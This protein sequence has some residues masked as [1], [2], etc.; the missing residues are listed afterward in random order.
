MKD[1]NDNF[2][3]FTPEDVSLP[4]D[5]VYDEETEDEDEFDGDK[6]EEEYWRRQEEEKQEKRKEK[7]KAVMIAVAVLSIIVIVLLILFT[8]I[9]DTYRRNFKNNFDKL[10]YTEP[11]I[12]IGATEKNSNVQ[13]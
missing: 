8:S 7:F 12:D 5:D 9:G 11:A 2:K 1:D 4:E 3:M 6:F 13:D 10:F